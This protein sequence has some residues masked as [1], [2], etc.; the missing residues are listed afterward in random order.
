MFAQAYAFNQPLNN[1]NTSKVTNMSN[2]FRSAKAFNQ[3]LNNWD[4]SKVTTM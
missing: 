2:M 4:T 1:W 3:P